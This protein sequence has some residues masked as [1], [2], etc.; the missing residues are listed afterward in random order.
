MKT[1]KFSTFCEFLNPALSRVSYNI[2]L[3][4]RKF[5]LLEAFK[6]STNLFSFSYKFKKTMNL[7]D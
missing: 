6:K 7:Y 2:V 4:E 5:I 3:S 1:S